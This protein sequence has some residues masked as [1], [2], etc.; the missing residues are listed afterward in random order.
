MDDIDNL[1]ALFLLL[2]PEERARLY[3]VLILLL[4][5]KIGGQV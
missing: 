3:V 2:N 5:E 1:A 4:I